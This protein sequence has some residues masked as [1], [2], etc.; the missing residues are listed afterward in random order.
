MENKNGKKS[1]LEGLLGG[2]RTA[3]IAG[4]SAAAGAAVGIYATL[5]GAT[6]YAYGVLKGIGSYLST[7]YKAFIHQPLVVAAGAVIGGFATY[8]IAALVGGLL[9][10]KVAKRHKA[11]AKPVSG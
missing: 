8:G 3:V 2:K 5:K 6:Q 11:K 7:G 9:G 1:R 4:S 10:Y